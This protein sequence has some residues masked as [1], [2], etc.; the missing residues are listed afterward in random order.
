MTRSIYAYPYLIEKDEDGGLNVT[1]P[2]VPEALTGTYDSGELH[3]LA[4]DCLICA[5]GGY[6]EEGRA[7]PKPSAAKHGDGVV[8]L[9]A[10]QASKLALH[11]AMMD[12]GMTKSALAHQLGIDARHVRRML[13]L[14]HSSKIDDIERAL[15]L[16]FGKRL[17]TGVMEAA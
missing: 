10:L 7:L 9:R 4:Y 13:D 2:D 17:V 11:N 5:L 8:Y 15:R 12:A 14:D 3:A 16:V 6:I 1:F